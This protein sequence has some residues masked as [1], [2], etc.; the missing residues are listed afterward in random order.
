VSYFESII[1]AKF[2]YVPFFIE[3]NAVDTASVICLIL[4]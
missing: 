3:K 4:S 1:T 2:N